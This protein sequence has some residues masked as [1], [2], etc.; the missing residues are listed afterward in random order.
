MAYNVSYGGDSNT[1]GYFLTGKKFD[2]SLLSHL[3]R[4]KLTDRWN[5]GI[6]D[7]VNEGDKMVFVIFYK[8][9]IQSLQESLPQNK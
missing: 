3:K 5:S 8:C 1:P 6:D 4:Y 2:C 7:G 9:L